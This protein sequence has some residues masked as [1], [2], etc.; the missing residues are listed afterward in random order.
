MPDPATIVALAAI[1]GLVVVLVVAL[2]RP[3]GPVTIHARDIHQNFAAGQTAQVSGS[4]PL[5]EPGDL[6]PQ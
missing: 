4:V 2:I 6:P 5:K 3:T 1:L